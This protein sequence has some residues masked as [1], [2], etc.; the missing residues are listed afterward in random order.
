MMQCDPT[1][2]L[3]KRLQHYSRPHPS[4]CRLWI[5]GQSSNGYGQLW[6]QGRLQRAHRLAWIIA[7]GPIPPGRKVCHQCDVKLCIEEGHLFLGTQLDNMRDKMRPAERS[8]AARKSQSMTRNASALIAG[9][10]KRSRE[11]LA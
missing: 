7:R 2:P 3:S 11:T 4:G 5:A 8:M 1:W 10:L 6:W 9:R